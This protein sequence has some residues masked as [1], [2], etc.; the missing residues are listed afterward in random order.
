MLDCLFNYL[1]LFVHYGLLYMVYF[2]FLHNLTLIYDAIVLCCV[3]DW[4]ILISFPTGIGSD[5]ITL[6]ISTLY[7][8][9]PNTI[10]INLEFVSKTNY[11][12]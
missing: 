2:I 1:N 7:K 11:Y 12:L 3:S 8:V 10:A 4:C 6:N 5:S 9:S